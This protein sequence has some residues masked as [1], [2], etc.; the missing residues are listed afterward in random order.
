M[1]RAAIGFIDNIVRYFQS[2]IKKVKFLRFMAKGGTGSRCG[3][4][5][6]GLVSD[7]GY[8]SKALGIAPASDEHRQCMAAGGVGQQQ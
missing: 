1:D 5:V 7:R 2:K 8:P 6:N 4:L 3:C